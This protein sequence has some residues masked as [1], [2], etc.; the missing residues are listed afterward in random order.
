MVAAADL[1]VLD[2]DVH[3]VSGIAEDLDA[4]FAGVVLGPRV[5]GERIA[6]LTGMARLC[7]APW[8]AEALSCRGHARMKLG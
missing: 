7:T 5:S 3:V 6:L 1:E 2:G 8:S 4:A